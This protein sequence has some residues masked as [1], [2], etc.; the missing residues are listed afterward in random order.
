VLRQAMEVLRL[1]SPERQEL[2]V[3]EVAGL[4]GRPRSSIS[5]WLRAM[6]DAGFLA[7]DPGSSR[8]RLGMEL[9]ALGELAR[10]SASLQPLARRVLEKLVAETEETSNLVVLDRGNAVN[11]EV[12]LSPRPIRHVGIL[13]RQLPL[14]ASAAGKVLV[15]W[16]PVQERQALLAPPLHG[17]TP[18]TITAPGPLDAELARVRRRGWATAWRELEEEV[19]AA[20]APVRNGRGEV[21]AALTTSAPV[22]RMPRERL[23]GLAR[24]VKRAADSLSREMGFRE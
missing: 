12:V 14:H 7:R 10:G 19:A 15:A 21:V 23:P 8:Y 17:F 18:R 16:L 24:R 22:S 1:F 4:L 20:A 11:V 2:G 9:V 5:R 13:G 6:A 3:V